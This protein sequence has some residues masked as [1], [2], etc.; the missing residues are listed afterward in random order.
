MY[1]SRPCDVFTFV[2]VYP[3]SNIILYLQQLIWL[4]KYI[5]IFLLNN[6]Y[7]LLLLILNRFTNK[8][9]KTRL[10]FHDNNY[11]LHIQTM[12]NQKAIE[13]PET[14]KPCGDSGKYSIQKLDF[15]QSFF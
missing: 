5:K 3:F 9:E 13:A 4:V 8:P 10:R 6:R 1:I 2:N 12:I 15:T 11:M 7:V 14:K